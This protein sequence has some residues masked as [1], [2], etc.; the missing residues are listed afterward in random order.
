MPGKARFSRQTYEGS[1][2]SRCWSYTPF[3]A[4]WDECAALR[5]DADMAEILRMEE[6]LA[7]VPEWAGNVVER[8]INYPPFCPHYAFPRPYLEVLDAIGQ[9]RPAA[10]IH[11]CYTADR[12]R[13]ERMGDYVLCLDAWRAGASAKEAAAEVAGRS[14]FVADWASICRDV[15]SVLGERSEVKQLLVGRTI[16]RQRWWMKTLVWDDDSRDVYCRDQYLGQVGCRTEGHG[17]YGNEAFEDPY[18][19]ELSVPE[20]EH[21]ERRL[22]EICTDWPV[23]RNLI[24]HSWLCAPK[25]FRFLERLLWC[26]GKEKIVVHLPDHPRADGEDVPDFLQCRDT[27]PDLAE[28]RGWVRGFSRGLRSWLAGGPPDGCAAQDVHHRLG[29]RSDLKVWVCRLYL[30]KMEFLNPYGAM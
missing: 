18:F 10:F 24:R 5:E 25:A 30:K 14:P 26:V 27:Y 16:H 8:S 7:P 3:N 15:W 1:I 12:N 4:G 2:S 29:D 28:A 23:F 6:A 11:G 20:V 19:A 17:H 22:A 13:K 21:T 9:Q